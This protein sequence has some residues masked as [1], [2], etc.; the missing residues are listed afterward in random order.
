MGRTTSKHAKCGF[1]EV[2]GYSDDYI[3]T[4][5]P[6]GWI[7]KDSP[8]GDNHDIMQHPVYLELQALTASKRLSWNLLRWTMLDRNLSDGDVEARVEFLK[9]YWHQPQFH[10]FMSNDDVWRLAANHK[11]HALVYLDDTVPGR[12][13]LTYIDKKGQPYS[14]YHPIGHAWL[15]SK[16]SLSEITHYEFKMPVIPVKL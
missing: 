8:L 3:P 15:R 9:T 12:L 1:M 13:N 16:S 5:T 4:C 11:G 14:S 7:T 10:Q 2:P 6:E